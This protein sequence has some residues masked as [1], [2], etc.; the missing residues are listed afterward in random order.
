MGSWSAA[1]GVVPVALLAACWETVPRLGLVDRVLLPPL[2][3]VLAEWPALF[4]S[5]ELPRHIL[6]TVRA[7]AE[8]FALAAGLG[9]AAGLLMGFLPAVRVMFSLLVELLRPMP[10]VATIPIAILLFGLGDAM[11][12][13]VVAYAGLW[14]VLLNALYGVRGVEPRLQDV[15]RTFRLGGWRIAWRILLPAASPVI[16]T[17]LRVGSGIALTLTVTVE[18]VAGQG[19]LGA[20]IADAQLAVRTAEMYAGILTVALLGFGLNALFLG[21]ETRV[22]A[23]HANA[24]TK[25]A[26]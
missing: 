23:W 3:Q 18:L 20:F 13:S 12:V 1:R 9:V 4:S 21:L 25:E 14:P 7:Y 17:G 5:G 19:G 2:S 22:L 15:G 8:G 11:K 24:T 16:A 10:S 6:L 26:G